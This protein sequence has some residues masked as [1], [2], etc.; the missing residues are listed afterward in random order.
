MRLKERKPSTRKMLA[1]RAQFIAEFLEARQ[2]FAFSAAVNFQPASATVPSGYVA[3]TGSVYAARGNGFTYGWDVDNASATRDRNLALSPDQRYDTFTHTQLSGASR[4]WEIAVPSGTYLVHVVAGD[5]STFDSTYKF[6]AENTPIVDAAP[7]TDRRWSEGTAVVTVTDGRLTLSNASGSVNNKLAYIDIIATADVTGP[8]VRGVNPS[9]GWTNIGRDAYVGVDLYLPNGALNPATV[10]TSTVTLRRASDGALVPASVNT[11]GGGDSIVLQP[12]TLL[13]ANTKYTFAI[14]SGVRDITGA[15]MTAYT[16]VF[17]TGTAGTPA[18]SNI[19]FEK[20]SLNV[21]ANQYTAVV[22]GP[23]NKLYAATNDGKIIRWTI[24]SDG[25]LG[26]SQTITSIQTSNNDERIITGLVFDPASTATN[27]IAWVNHGPND[28]TSAPDWSGKLTRLSGSNL[29]NVRDAVIGLPRSAHDHLS[30]QPVFGPDGALYFAQGSNTAQGSPDVSWGSRPEHLLNGAIL[31]VNT[32]VL[33]SSTPLNVQTE[34]RG[35]AN[36]NPWLASAPV[37][38]YATGVR[39]AYDLVWTKD[40]DGTNRL[41]VPNNGSAAGG[42]TPATPALPVP[43]SVRIDGDDDSNPNN[44]MYLGPAVPAINPLNETQNDYLYLINEGGGGYY[45]HPNPSRSEYVLNGG[46][47][48]SGT[49]PFEVKSYPVGTQPDRNYRGA[50]FDFGAKHSANGILEYKSNAFNGALKGKLLVVQYSGGD[51][52]VALSRSGGTITGSQ[53]GMTGTTGFGDP[54]DLVED[55]RNGN[56][57]VAEYGAQTIKL[58]RPQVIATPIGSY[59]SADIGSPAIAGSTTQVTDGVAYNVTAAGTDISGT[60]DQF[61][62]VYKQMAG[63]FDMRVRVASLTQADIFSQ[64]GLMA[65]ASLDANSANVIMKARPAS[66]G[67]RFNYRATAG[68]TT[69]GLGSGAVSYP[70]TWLRLQRVGNVF[71]GYGS[72]DGVNW[73]QIGQISLALPNTLFFGMAVSSKDVAETTTAQF[74]DL[75][76]T[77]GLTAPSSLAGTVAS[78][79]R[80]NLTWADRSTG[81]SGFKVQR[82]TGS[83]GTY[84]TI[85]TTGAGATSYA[86]TSV[87]ANTTYFY[88]VIAT[89]VAGDSTPSNE[90]SVT[91]PAVLSIPIAPSGLTADRIASRTISLTW[92][93]NSNNETGF[94]IYRRTLFGSY[95]LVATIGAG[96]DSY[97]DRDLSR[98]TTYYYQ[99]VAYNAAGESPRSNTASA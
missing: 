72:T 24:N 13:D 30:N 68:G 78:S 17:T 61:R 2:L 87:S 41:W 80:V 40:A 9:N 93:D 39:N 22:M 76:S 66:E 5:P 65:R 15:A 21:P 83:G 4:T 11:S 88:R 49:D 71:T 99:V 36:Y 14:S 20:V 59:T 1:R 64:A 31:R 26:S 79:T 98:R 75:G 96:V 23:D 54:L 51:N 60:S 58:L 48:T 8:R 57:Y 95:S 70:N 63:D 45:G 7:N 69:T 91:T 33:T 12:T 94:R 43:G 55:T 56:L 50:A 16:G 52:I 62:F 67:Y 42:S 84:V 27:L 37:R 92:N 25:T 77:S 3:D 29:Q 46:N 6:N 35:S 74:R 32:A 18:S 10:T 97:T 86:D 85:A 44:G 19:S 47:P 73:T 53:V 89:G 82:K 38:L 90:I 28:F 81:E 34:G